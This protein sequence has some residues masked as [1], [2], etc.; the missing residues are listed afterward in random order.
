M[1]H[2]RFT[3]LIFITLLWVCSCTFNYSMEGSA[4]E[5]VPDMVLSEAVIDR[6][7]DGA[8]AVQ[9][10]AEKLEMYDQDRVW[11]GETVA[12]TSF[13]ADTSQQIDTT[14]SAGLLLIDDRS[15]LYSL[16]NTAYFYIA[17]DDMSI[18]AEALRWA[19]TAHTLSGPQNSEV[20]LVKGDGTTIRGNGFS[21]DT[22]RYAYR[23]DSAVSGLLPESR[24]E[25]PSVQEV[26][27]E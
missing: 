19:K 20:V 8:L 14:G 25:E 27:N 4:L 11:A 13:S 3:I 17:S 18:H 6:Y 23:F 12:F 24:E 5:N 2:F 9:L 16:G 21:A 1:I 7:E 26:S 15:G 22:L 10:S